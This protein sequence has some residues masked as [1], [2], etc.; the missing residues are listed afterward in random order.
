MSDDDE[1]S[2]FEL[3]KMEAEERVESLQRLLLQVQGGSGDLN[4]L[5]SLMRDAHSLK[6]AAR[7]AEIGSAVSLTHAME[8]R[9]VAAEEGRSLAES[10][11]DLLLH[12]TDLL[13]SLGTLADEAAAVTWEGG[14]SQEITGLVRVLCDAA[15][16]ASDTAAAAQAA[17]VVE[18]GKTPSPSAEPAAAEPTAT[19]TESSLRMSSARLG[20]ILAGASDS[21][22]RIQAL[23]EMSNRLHRSE[24][25]LYRSLRILTDTAEATA[26]S[27]SPV[28]DA[29]HRVRSEQASMRTLLLELDDA[30]H[31]GEQVA[32]TLHREVLQA[33]MR[34]LAE[35]VPGWQRLVRSVSAELDKKVR[36]E[37]VGDRTD[38]D[39][40]ILEQLRAPL[41]HLI[42]NSLDHGLES[43]EARVAAGKQET[44]TIRV[45]ARHQNGR[46]AISVGDD[47]AGVDFRAVRD[48]AVKRGLVLPSMTAKMSEDEVLQFLFLPGFSTRESVSEISGRGF[49]LDV[50]QSTVQGAGGALRIET[51]LG[52]GTTIHI[53][54]PIS[55]SVMRVMRVGVEDE[56]FALPATRLARVGSVSVTAHADGSRT[57]ETEENVRIPIVPLLEAMG[58]TATPLEAG[59]TLAVFLLDGETGE[60]EIALAVDRLLGDVLVAVRTPDPRLGRSASLAGVTLT[61]RGVPMLILDTDNLL[62]TALGA[63]RRRWSMSSASHGAEHVATVLVADDSHTVRQM[64]RRA[65]V[66]AHYRVVTAAHGAE[67]WA[68]LQTQVFDLLISDVDMPEMTGIE[69][70]E[71]VRDN[72]RLQHMPVVLLSYKGREEDRRRGLEA[73]ADMYF[74]K[75]EFEENAFLQVVTDLIGPS[76]LETDIVGNATVPAQEPASNSG[77]GGPWSQSAS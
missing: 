3:F 64:L 48:R 27:D 28:V 4:V 71:H 12:C 63:Q 11:V 6:G 73:G 25:R 67:A 2:I 19:A 62:R 65:L 33:R 7:I 42:R 57:I 38:V 5:H 9:F 40:D 49:G 60:A 50:V 1:L 32:G 68:L 47:G 10:E 18:A 56:V 72:A 58:G 30:V 76:K 54:L 14:H 74:S 35:I 29:V 59:H 20:R 31:I 24:E 39:R 23:M 70:T 21:L 53:T 46:L 51:Q 16:G 44:G 26:S 66:R 17:P 77:D 15:T 13:R 34:P 8:D 22:V 55:R 69:L 36:L 61:D 37:I 43:S 52:K 45:W 41:E 75:G